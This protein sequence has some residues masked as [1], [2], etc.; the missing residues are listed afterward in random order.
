MRPCLPQGPGRQQRAAGRSGQP[1]LISKVSVWLRPA[2]SVTLILTEY[3]PKSSGVAVESSPSEVMEK[4]PT[5]VVVR[6]RARTG[7]PLTRV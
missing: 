3:P 7:Q 5:V 6:Q 4:A 2:R 1:T